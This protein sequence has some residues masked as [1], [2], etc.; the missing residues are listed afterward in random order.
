MTSTRHFRPIAVSVALGLLLALASAWLPAAF[1][2]VN[3][4]KL[5]NLEYEKGVA[6]PAY[7]GAPHDWTL[8][9]WHTLRGPGIRYDLVSECEWMGSKLGSSPSTAPNRTLQRITTG[10]PLPA[11]Q[12]DSNPVANA[13]IGGL[14]IAGSSTIAGLVARRLPIRPLVVPFLINAAVFA[15]AVFVLLTVSSTIRAARRRSRGLCTHC[16]YPVS[17]LATCPEC[18]AATRPGLHSPGAQPT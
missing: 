7:V 1:L 4:G 17:G 8:R 14:P 2:N 12:Y 15:L 11:M 5:H 6:I 10:W 16:A 13:W 18:G 9:T 3:D